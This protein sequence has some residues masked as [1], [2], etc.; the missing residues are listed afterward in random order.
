MG[1]KEKEF[2]ARR[3]R[4]HARRAARAPA[5]SLPGARRARLAF[6]TPSVDPRAAL[7]ARGP[8]GPAATPPMFGCDHHRWGTCAPTPVT[9]PL[10]GGTGG[11]RAPFPASAVLAQYRWG[12]EWD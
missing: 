10:G 3:R 4:A 1:V 12:T 9:S 8:A 5:T 6:P 2:G 11:G 7:R